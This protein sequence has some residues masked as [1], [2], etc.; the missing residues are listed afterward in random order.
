[1]S[2][3]QLNFILLLILSLFFTSC[4]F[5]QEK[6]GSEDAAKNLSKLVGAD[7]ASLNQYVFQPKCV[8]CHTEPT[9]N[10]HHIV[11]TN[12]QTIINST[13]FPP[14]V[15]PGKPEQ[16]SLYTAM[17]SGRMPKD[18]GRMPEHVIKMVFEWIKAG[19]PETGTGPNQPCEENDPNCGGGSPGC[20]PEEPGCG[21]EDDP[22]CQ[23]DEPGCGDEGGGPICQPDEPGCEEDWN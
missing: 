22:V 8:R 6:S 12:Y 3:V 20:E 15:V 1:M 13:V 14:L 10:N 19:A 4:S 18:S 2:T 21:D 23:P 7:F 11:L 5:R 16:S 17:A 9:Q